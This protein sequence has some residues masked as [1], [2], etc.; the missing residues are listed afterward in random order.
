MRKYI[1]T[2]VC[3]ILTLLIL[4]FFTGYGA[5]SVSAASLPQKPAP[6]ISWHHAC[7]STTD[8]RA[9]CDALV[10]YNTATNAPVAPNA[11]PTGGSAPYGPANFH[12]AYNLPTTASGTPTVAIV[13]AYNNPN[14]AS[15]LATYRSTYGLPA[16]TTSTGAANCTSCDDSSTPT[17]A[18][19]RN[20]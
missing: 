18:R 9:F 17:K 2:A 10:A 13:D 15:N 3:T 14:A 5:V 20:R 16:C 19:L 7:S 11:N 1:F 6:T 8:G 4:T 12:A